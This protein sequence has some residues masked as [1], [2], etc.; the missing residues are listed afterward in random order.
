ML[1]KVVTNRDVL[2]HSQETSVARRCFRSPKLELSGGAT[3]KTMKYHGYY[4]CFG[5]GSRESAPSQNT[6][7]SC[8][9]LRNFGSDSG[10][11][12]VFSQIVTFYAL[13][14]RSD[15]VFAVLRESPPRKPLKYHSNNVC[16][17]K[18][19]PFQVSRTAD[20]GGSP[21]QLYK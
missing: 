21:P 16:F 12:C 9:I 1:K 13:K 6:N 10:V 5:T 14:R 8:A 19:Q 15:C 4:Q 2:E 17:A 18:G 7:Y 11:S 20:F 3:Q